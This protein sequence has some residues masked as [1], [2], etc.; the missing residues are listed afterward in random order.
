MFY[1]LSTAVWVAETVATAPT[2]TLDL[3]AVLFRAREQKYTAMALVSK[4]N[5]LG[6]VRSGR[7]CNQC[8][9]HFPEA[10]NTLR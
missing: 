8:H 4:A 5:L 2:L 10:D 6:F 9:R 3:S 7:P 1:Q